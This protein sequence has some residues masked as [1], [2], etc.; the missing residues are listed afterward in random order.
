MREPFNEVVAAEVTR[1]GGGKAAEGLAGTL[2]VAFSKMT[3][4]IKRGHD[5][6]Q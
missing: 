3:L 1:R 2:N 6:D 5:M 4:A